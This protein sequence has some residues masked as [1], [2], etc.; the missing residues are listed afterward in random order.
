MTI[1]PAPTERRPRGRSLPLVAASAALS[2]VALTAAAVPATPAAA[3]ALSP[4]TA[5]QSVAPTAPVSRVEL[6]AQVPVVYSPDV[7]IEAGE[8]WGSGS[9]LAHTETG[10]VVLTAA[11]V[12]TDSP[13]TV[14]AGDGEPVPVDVVNCSVEVLDLCVLHTV[15]PLPT[16]IRGEL[17]EVNVGDEVRLDGQASPLSIGLVTS[18]ALQLEVTDPNGYVRMLD[19]AVDLSALS[20]PGDSGAGVVDAEGRLVGMNDGFS[21]GGSRAFMVSGKSFVLEV[22]RLRDGVLEAAK[23]LVPDAEASR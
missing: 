7:L 18:D 17:G 4:R 1:T 6:L 21:D 14:S 12:L 22:S 8:G 9:V 2:T 23:D 11:H 15:E 5:V 16:S 10:S 13:V 20:H 3:A 19:S